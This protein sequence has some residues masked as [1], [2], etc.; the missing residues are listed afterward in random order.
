MAL[1]H[2]AYRTGWVAL[3]CGLLFACGGSGGDDP[4]PPTARSYAMGFTDFPNAESVAGLE[5][6]YAVIAR[7]ADMA[8]MHMDEGVPWAEA[9]ANVKYPQAYL[10][11]LQYKVNNIPAGHV[12]YLAL[13]PLNMERDGL[14]RYRGA[15]PNQDLTPPWDTYALNDANVIQAFTQYCLTMIDLFSPDYFAYAIE[16]NIL[17]TKNDAKWQEFVELAEKV[18]EQIK[19]AH[20][21]LPVFITLQAEDFHAAPLAQ[22]TAI[23]LILPYVDMIAVS[24]YPYMTQDGSLIDPSNIPGDY[25]S[26]LADLAPGKPF[27]IAETAWPAEDITDITDPANVFVPADP[28][29]QQLYVKRLLEDMDQLSATFV[30]LF[31][32][33]DFDDMWDNVL[34]DDPNLTQEEK[35]LFRAWKDTGL[36]D[37]A[38]NPRV[39]LDSWRATLALPRR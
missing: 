1:T 30:T 4:A 9:W 26:A 6:A 14:A 16:A 11:A 5:D 23:E 27:A 25:F 33:R 3:L 13:T 18:Y 29:A 31:F 35:Q 7:D 2:T 22:T 20:R 38:G 21:D 12:V 19:A 37:G 8:V 24:S 32:T 28:A 36:Y 15:N 17:H 10:D 39:A 34:K